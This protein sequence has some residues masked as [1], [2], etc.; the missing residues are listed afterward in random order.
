MHWGLFLL[1]PPNGGGQGQGRG[2]DLSPGSDGVCIRARPLQCG[3]R[4]GVWDSLS[5]D[6]DKGREWGVSHCCFHFCHFSP[7]LV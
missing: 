6:C 5:V 4:S 7:F 1:L 2:L 3:G